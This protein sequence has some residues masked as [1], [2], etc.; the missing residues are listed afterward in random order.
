MI[1]VIPN[2]IDHKNLAPVL[3]Q[4]GCTTDNFTVE[5]LGGGLINSTW[6]VSF[7]DTE[8]VL[9]KVNT[10]V[11]TRPEHIAHNIERVNNYLKKEAPEYYFPAPLLNANNETF[12]KDE[13]GN[14][15]R[16]FKFLNG[17]QTIAVVANSNQAYEAAKQFGRFNALLRDFP[18]HTLHENIAGFHNLTKR[19]NDFLQVL[20]TGIPER[21]REASPWIEKALE[22]AG[23]VKQ[24]DEIIR[25]G[26]IKKRVTH[27]DTKISN[28]LFNPAG[29]AFAVIDL[30][31]IMAGYYISDVGDM[32]RTYLSLTGEEEQFFEE[33]VI[34]P[35][36]YQAIKEGYMSEMALH[37]SAA[38]RE[39]FYYSGQFLIFMQAIRF[40]SD[41]LSGDYYYTPAYPGHNF[42]RAQH[43]LQLLT[44][45]SQIPA[46]QR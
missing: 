3:Q 15:Y 29:K 14:W 5:R 33:V 1:E 24:Y 19:Y 26:L 13:S 44:A 6:K 39:Y 38:E 40:L 42:K 10:H 43:Q 32:M 41:Y 30:D 17:S 34:R 4:Y 8:L 7:D 27:H 12:Y 31:T 28:V 20:K 9:Q 11:F 37:L 36:V 25:N 18:A 2:T 16:A 22:H 23:I 45:Y 21:L 35:E 46:A